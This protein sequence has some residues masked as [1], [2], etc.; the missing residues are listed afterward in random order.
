VID[1]SRYNFV[2]ICISVTFLIAP[3]YPAPAFS[4]DWLSVNGRRA[5]A[6]P[7]L[8]VSGAPSGKGLSVSMSIG[9]AS[10]STVRV[11]AKKFDQ[12]SIPGC[13]ATAERIG[14]PELPFKG[15]FIEVPCG[16]D[17]DVTLRSEKTVSLGTG[18]TVMPLQPPLPDTPSGEDPPFEIDDAAYAADA[19][20]PAE[21]VVAAEPGF[22]RGRRV[23]FVQVF[24]LRY[25]PVTTELQALATTELIVEFTG[26]PD[27]AGTARRRRL[28]GPQWEALAERLILNYEPAEVE[29]GEGTGAA[30]VGAYGRG[31]SSTTAADY[32]IIVADDLYE[33]VLPLAEWKHKK[34]LV[35]R[36]VPMSDVGTTASDVDA[37]IQDAYDTWN[38]APSYVLLVGDHGDIPADYYSGTL[39]CYSDLAFACTDGSDYYPD[40]TLGRLP[41]QTEAECTNVVNKILL[42]D[43]T[44]DSGGWYDDFLSAGY[45]QDDDNGSY[46]DR[47]FMETS[48]TVMEF[49]RDTVGYAAHTAWTTNS[50][51][52]S[53]YHYRTSSYPHRFSYPD[54][55]PTDV[56]SAWTSASQSTADITTAINNGVGIVQHR[57]HGG[58]TGWGD[59]PFY[60]SNVNSLSN[61]DMT[62]VV[63]SINCQTG[64]FTLSSDCFC[65]AFIKKSPGGSVA[66]VGATRNSY[67]GYNDLLV[68]GIYTC[69]WPAYDT[70]HTDTTYTV[71]WRPA[72]ALNYGKYYMLTYEGTGSY[73]EGE[74]YMFHY[75]GDPEIML[76]TVTPASLAVSHPS[77]IQ[78]SVPTNVTVTVNSGGSPVEGALVAISSDAA[79]DDYWTGTTNGSGEAVFTD[80]TASLAAD[81]DIV[82]TAHD[83]VPYE[84]TITSAVGSDGVVSLDEESY[85]CS[86]DIAIWV[87]DAN[88]Q[89]AGT[90]EVELTATGGD[91]ET[92]VLDETDVDTAIFTGAISTTDDGVQTEDG[93]LQVS[94]GE[95]ITVTYIDADDGDG[96]TNVPKTDQADADCQAPA[97]S[98]VSVGSVTKD[99]ATISWTTDEEATGEVIYG[100]SPDDLGETSDG[101]SPG[102]SH[103]VT[104][105]NLSNGTRHYFEIVATD[106][107]GYEATDN[108]GGACYAFTTNAL[109]GYSTGFEDGELGGEWTAGSDTSYGRIQVTTWNGP[110]TGSY[111]VTM[112]VSSSGNYNTNDLTLLA[113]LSAVSSDAELT[114]WYKEWNDEDHSAD[115]VS[116]SND[117]ITFTQARSHNGGSSSWTEYAVD[118]DDAA[119]AAGLTLDLPLY[120]RWTQYDNY[121]LGS[122]GIAIDD[123]VAGG[124][125]PVDTDGDG[126][127][128]NDDTDDDND[129]LSDEEEVRDYGTD[130]A[131]S[132]TD[133]DGLNDG[134]EISN[135]TDPLDTDS[136]DDCLSDGEEVNTHGTNPLSAN[137]D[138]DDWCDVIE[139]AGG[140]DPMIYG[141]TT[142]EIMVRISF[143][144]GYSERPYEY[145]PSTDAGY[146]PGLG[147]GWR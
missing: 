30:A 28:A 119:A 132:D 134:D 142:D 135:S 39:S 85:S 144:P 73:T 8:S 115:G 52:H 103:S 68:H 55:V 17:I 94:H 9:G 121:I 27:P 124:Y 123:I 146:S 125:L 136:D 111:H 32:L 21:A 43:R 109:T 34:G 78:Q 120:I 138:G 48:V 59:P 71:S 72:E 49:L 92:V 57:D 53:T 84:G 45:F 25:N 89:G 20:Y 7:S 54:P 96:G 86:S 23:V 61:G 107:V 13:G 77:V 69:F 16:V 143:Q 75:F 60:V 110:R 14:L 4:E 88:L 101:T 102:T 24:P 117:G 66:I 38:P 70:S 140:S 1:K 127:P 58:T 35:T 141:W 114:Y 50:S 128:D 106:G 22:I 112:D 2:L 41:V 147:Y 31:L 82:V 19:F 18:Y 74:F 139:I 137:S 63:F 26:L 3:Q 5:A 131:S 29:E 67:S 11:E 93:T 51:G 62:P 36:V 116:I 133:G 98:G 33:E 99:S 56:V 76:R 118:L 97:I 122:D 37:Y 15:F 90:Q 95:T 129:G 44:P 46:A 126:T 65:E 79:P 64:S 47:W 130:P 12:L 87:S 108:N 145:A 42:Y 6:P 91:I 40:V 104:L 100:T 10:R 113:D 105:D 80:L 81:Y 83:S